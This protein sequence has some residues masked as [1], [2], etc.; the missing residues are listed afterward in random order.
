MSWL[1]V[2]PSRCPNGRWAYCSF[3]YRQ[4]CQIHYLTHRRLAGQRNELLGVVGEDYHQGRM[5]A[6]DLGPKKQLTASRK[7]FQPFRRGTATKTFL[8]IM[9][10]EEQRVA[11]LMEEVKEEAKKA[12]RERSRLLRPAGRVRVRIARKRKSLQERRPRRRVAGDDLA[13][14]GQW[15]PHRRG[16]LPPRAFWRRGRRFGSW[17]N[18]TSTPAVVTT[19]FEQ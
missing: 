15:R 13:R 2:G 9:A 7:H 17:K 19:C 12:E 3:V 18:T 1:F 5:D 4:T 8:Q 11:G 10:V 14:R 16:E 6:A